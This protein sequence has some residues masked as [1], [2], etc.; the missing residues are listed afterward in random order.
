MASWPR[1]ES[2]SFLNYRPGVS[3]GG[4]IRNASPRQIVI[5]GALDGRFHKLG[6]EL[7]LAG[8]FECGFLISKGGKTIVSNGQVACLKGA[9]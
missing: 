3:W 8:E 1:W 7:F 9:R 4:R 2:G 5:L 6:D